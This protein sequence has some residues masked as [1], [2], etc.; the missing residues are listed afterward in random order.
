MEL[1]IRRE[2]LWP[3]AG[4][5][6]SRRRGQE[7]RRVWGARKREHRLTGKTEGSK[8]ISDLLEEEGELAQNDFSAI[9]KPVLP[10]AMAVA[11]RCAH[12]LRGSTAAAGHRLGGQG[13]M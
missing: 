7:P 3:K 10:N 11:G 13:R 2:R 9:F 8:R 1:G 6:G 5:R 12:Q 4:S